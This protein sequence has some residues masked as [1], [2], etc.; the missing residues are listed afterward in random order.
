MATILKRTALGHHPVE[1]V[2]QQTTWRA[3]VWL[4]PDVEIVEAHTAPTVADVL[5][6]Q[7][8]K[9]HLPKSK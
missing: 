5:R 9:V 1:I 2:A 7:H 4:L 8:A 6:A 3:Y